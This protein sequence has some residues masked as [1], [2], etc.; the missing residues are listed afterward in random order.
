MSEVTAARHELERHTAVA[1]LAEEWDALA[2]RCGASPFLRPGW[3][4]A[5][6]R[7][8]GAGQLEVTALR[9]SGRLAG[10]APLRRRRGQ[11]SSPTNWHSPEFGWVAEDDDA[12][13]A[14]TR[15]VLSGPGPVDLRFLNAGS[16][17][18]VAVAA[19]A[20]GLGMRVLLRPLERSPYVGLDEGWEAYEATLH[21]RTRSEIRR[22]RRRLEEQGHLW[23]QVADGTAGLDALLEEGFRVEGSGWKLER[24]TAIVSRPE[25]QRFYEDI[26]RWAAERGW[27]R[28]A[29]LRLDDRPL[30]FQLLVQANGVA[31]QLKG[32]H[33]PEFRRSAPG[34]LLAHAV[35]E[36]LAQEG[37]SSYEFLG[38]DDPF[39]LE[40]A[41]HA[42]ERINL[43]AFPAGPA[44]LAAW[45]AHAHGRPLAK[46]GRA[47]V[48]SWTRRS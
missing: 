17:D 26:A 24:G 5:W 7:A 32:G 40:F 4:D 43:Q 27:L 47:L 3:F 1:P 39:K 8:F 44:G 30:A 21:R 15:V 25:T 10:V 34:M 22:R 28:L 46:R 31:S 29:F 20:E 48:A 11:R 14:L 9:R 12:R 19:T 23:L 41:R 45:T 42:R 37:L 38:T 2:D 35:L 6:W 33:D 18:A 13:A 36:R 16:P